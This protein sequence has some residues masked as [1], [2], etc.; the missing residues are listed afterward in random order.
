MISR[1]IVIAI[2][3]IIIV[4]FL[5]F[6]LNN[7]KFDTK[8]LI[9]N[10]N[11]ITVVKEYFSFDDNVPGEENKVRRNR[12]VNNGI[13]T[14]ELQYPRN[15]KYNDDSLITDN[16]ESFF[17][18]YVLLIDTDFINQKIQEYIDP[19]GNMQTIFSS[20]NAS[21]L[22]FT[23]L[24]QSLLNK[25][26]KASYPGYYQE[27]I[28][29][30]RTSDKIYKDNL[31]LFGIYSA[32][33]NNLKNKRQSS[34][35]FQYRYKF[36]PEQNNP[37]SEELLLTMVPLQITEEQI[38]DNI[39]N[40]NPRLTPSV[41]I[42]STTYN[43]RILSNMNNSCNQ[44]QICY[45]PIVD[46][47]KPYIFS[48][49]IPDDKKNYI[50]TQLKY[51]IDN[52]KKLTELA[53]VKE[54]LIINSDS[55]NDRDSEDRDNENRDSENNSEN[56]NNSGNRNNYNTLKTNPNYINLQNEINSVINL[57]TFKSDNIYSEERSDISRI[58]DIVINKLN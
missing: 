57:I 7:N 12:R 35:R 38:Y 19:S 27:S 10:I 16:I 32:I 42:N 20:K 49:N 26:Y 50:A 56:R 22:D 23:G 9:N 39:S 43:N 54:L 15:F 5:V 58:K 29:S 41:T 1:K 52:I 30:G 14:K 6:K 25:L 2:L 3:L 34:R 28:P 18:T 36:N 51:N 55:R 24:I 48:D 33:I 53:I 11:N 46:Y 40:I 8:N 17:N 21:L 4:L 44:N 45:Y 37:T 47:V 13:K 31:Y